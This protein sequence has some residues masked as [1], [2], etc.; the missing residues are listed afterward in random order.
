M[1]FCFLPSCLAQALYFAIF[2]LFIFSVTQ[3]SNSLK[4]WHKYHSVLKTFLF[5]CKSSSP[6]NVRDALFFLCR[7]TICFIIYIYASATSPIWPRAPLGKC[8]IAGK[9]CWE[10]MNRSIPSWIIQ[11][12][13]G[14]K[15]ETNSKKGLNSFI[16]HWSVSHY[17][18][19]WG[20]W[21]D[22]SH[23]SFIYPAFAEGCL[24]VKPHVEGCGR[25]QRIRAV[26]WKS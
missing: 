4:T 22:T 7:F 17:W 23:L 26:S 21:G 11:T 9:N 16:Q 6:L 13:T 8:L 14:W 10:Q 24:Y 15:Y 3:S 25:I 18:E 19:W 12:H 2:L 20:L 5:P 1:W